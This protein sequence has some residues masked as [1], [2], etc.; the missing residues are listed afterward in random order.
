M[1][2]R[3][4]SSRLWTIESTST[5]FSLGVFVLSARWFTKKERQRRALGLWGANP[6]YITDDT[7]VKTILS[8]DE[9]LAALQQQSASSSSPRRGNNHP[10][11]IIGSRGVLAME[12]SRASYLED[13]MYCL[14]VRFVVVVSVVDGAILSHAHTQT[15]MYVDS[16]ILL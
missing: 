12:T 9:Q 10:D 3:P 8:N 6:K 11:A 1:S 2:S 5:L 14:H 16:F 4:S 15:N 7:T 13:F